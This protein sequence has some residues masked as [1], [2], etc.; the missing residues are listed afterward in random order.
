[1][2][3]DLSQPISD[4]MPG[5]SLQPDPSIDAVFDV[6]EDGLSVQYV[7]FATHTGTTH[8]D[9][10][11]HFVAGGETIERIPV[12][13]FVSEAVVLDVS[14]G[15]AREITLGEIE[16]ADGEVRAGDVVILYT[17]W[18]HEY[19]TDDYETW[20]WVAPE[21]ADWLVERDVSMLCVDA[22]SPDKPE[23]VRSDDYDFPVH[24]TLLGNGV[25]IAEH[26]RNLADLAGKR[27][28]LIALP[29]GIEDGDGAPARF[30]ADADSVR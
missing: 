1:M 15:E 10:P 5:T 30:I 28:D 24:R 2:W 18:Y 9:A 14:V 16:A 13:R 23:A 11:R 19:G 4:D 22:T 8:I 12:D 3:I 20:P 26:L 25:L 21:A 17:G 27:F 29:V 7:C 6:E